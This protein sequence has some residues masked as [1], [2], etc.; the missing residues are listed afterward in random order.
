MMFVWLNSQWFQLE[1][2]KSGRLHVIVRWLYLSKTRDD[3]Y[4]V[5]ALT[6]YA[7]NALTKIQLS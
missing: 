1:N 5:Y 6:G 4:K 7:I 2:V 3:I